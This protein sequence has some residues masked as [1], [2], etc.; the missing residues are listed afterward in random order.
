MFA[1]ECFFWFGDV[2][3]AS[4]VFVYS[5]SWCRPVYIGFLWTTQVCIQQ[6]RLRLNKKLSRQS[7]S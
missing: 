5:R 4:K 1:W 7:Q 6:G 3:R 2:E